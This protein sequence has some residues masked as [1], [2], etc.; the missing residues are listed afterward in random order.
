MPL[1]QGR[2]EIIP[3]EPDAASTAGGKQSYLMRMLRTPCIICFFM[4]G[5]LFTAVLSALVPFSAAAAENEAAGNPAEEKV[6]KLDSAVVSASRAGKKTPVTYSM[7]YREEL[8]KSNPIN[9]LPMMLNLYP[10]VVAVNEGGTGLGYSKMTV[11]G[12]KGSQINVTLNGITLNDAESQEVFW[13]NIPSLANLLSSVQL[14]RG[15]GTSSNGPGAFGA[16][17]NM[18]TASAG[19]DPYV[20]VSLSAGSYN[21]FMATAA[22]GTGLTESGLYFDFAYSRNYT[23]GYIRNAKARLQS[24]FAALGW[25]SGN[26]S[27]KLT[28]L[29]GEQHTGITWNGID[30]DTYHSDRRYNSA[31]EYFDSF[32]NIHYYDNETDNYTQHHVQLNYTHKF[33]QSLVWSTTLN[34]TKGDG[35]YE[36][37]YMDQLFDDYNF[38]DADNPVVITDP[39][40]GLTKSFTSGDMIVREAMDNY[41]MVLDSDL[42]YS[43]EKLDLTG[44][45]NLSRYLGG[46]FGEVVWSQVHGDGYDYDAYNNA[47]TWYRNESL[48]QELNVFARAE[49][50][51][52]SWLTAYLDLQYRGISLGME[53]PDDD[54][55]MLD[56][57]T[58][59][60]FFN[61]RAGLT[62]SWKQGHK[63]YVSAALGNREPGRSDIKENIKSLNDG[64]R[65]GMTVRPEKMV[66]VEI[67]YV[68]TAPALTASVNLYFM[69]Y[70]DMLLETGRLTDVGYAIKE[71]VDRA[72]RRG[73]ELAAA[74]QARPWFRLDANATLSI[75]RVENYGMYG[76]D[77]AY[78]EYGNVT[79]LMSPSVVSML[80]LSFTPFRNTASN[81]L[82]TTTLTLNG[83]YVGKQYA[84]NTCNEALSV[85]GYFVSNL[86]LSH[87][88][89]VRGGKLGICGYINNLLNS[90]YYA[91]AVVYGT[92]LYVYP[93]APL[94]FM[95]KLSY[96]F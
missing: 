48:K 24:A 30:L 52:L 54:A 43:S 90:L 10:S 95:L 92:D 32:G 58:R 91:D 5:F 65:E 36:D 19:A 15:L 49:Y 18:S 51:P 6:E 55:G 76:S 82:R 71:N 23:D 73:I 84:D 45:I 86:S 59:W 29:M 31:G 85:P 56:Y 96:R 50:S 8:G 83:K 64:S 20:N 38:Q 40:T 77:G 2:A 9:S 1:P 37:Y 11:R 3:I 75:N 93:Q 42:K 78:T 7:V 87:E 57:G 16:S 60:N 70:F 68:Y 4:R 81:S 13:V 69:E 12:S 35:Y 26:N 94:N 22:A 63:A 61:P 27:L 66:D 46:H 89:D 17:V 72:Y 80:Q 21:T 28:Y 47:D 79:M 67:G 25:M 62:F 88:F 39:Q 14:Q 44:G 74:W 41:Y 34:F 53:G 33:P